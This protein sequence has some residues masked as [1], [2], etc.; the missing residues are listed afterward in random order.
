MALFNQNSNTTNASSSKHRY[1][2][3]QP[4]ATRTLN[5]S[6]NEMMYAPDPSSHKFYQLCH[7]RHPTTKKYNGRKF[8]VN[9]QGVFTDVVSKEYT[10]DQMKKFFR[11]HKD[12]EY[13]KYATYDINTVPF[14]KV[15]EILMAQSPLLNTDN[16]YTGF[17]K[18]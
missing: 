11:N 12:N 6:R 4:L 10:S 17:A 18:F 13:K 1:V 2:F 3:G 16:D 7:F 15:G 5:K 14:P 9:E 8:V